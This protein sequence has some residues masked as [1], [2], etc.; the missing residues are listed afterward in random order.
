MILAPPPQPGVVRFATVQDGYAGGA[1]GLLATHDGGRTWRTTPVAGPV[2][3][4]AVVGGARAWAASGSAVWRTTNGG[5]TWSSTK[6]VG[7]RQLDF[8]DGRTGFAVGNR[9]GVLRTGDGGRSWRRVA[10]GPLDS[11]CFTTRTSG[12]AA[13]RGLVLRTSDGGRTWHRVYAAPF[14]PWSVG[15][16]RCSGSSVWVLA[17]DG[18]A[19][20]SEGYLVY[21]TIDGERWFPALAQAML[22]LPLPPIDAYSGPFD[23][24]DPQT[25]VFVGS[26]S[27]CG[28]WTESLIRTSNAGQ[29]WR[30]FPRILD[31]YPPLAVSFPTARRG[32]LLTARGL[33]WRTDDGGRR[34]RRVL[35]SHALLSS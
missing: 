4:L 32:Y 24:V 3:A 12:W 34:W 1:H 14:G 22:G 30:R 31:G 33:L 19:A 20:G 11:V 18:V 10:L 5:K 29:G 25:A 2:R 28:H 16:V 17:R 6:T 35:R 9:G 21:R 13:R 27:P 26:C 15:D 8:V 7:V 23:V